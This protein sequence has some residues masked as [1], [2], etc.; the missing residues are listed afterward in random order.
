MIRFNFR[1]S[2]NLPLCYGNVVVYFCEN[3]K[4][5]RSDR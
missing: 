4:L 1:V 5:T 2:V 3:F